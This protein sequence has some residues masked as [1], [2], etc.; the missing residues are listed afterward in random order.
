[1]WL[2]YIAPR[3][4]ESEGYDRGP[5]L[6]GQQIALVKRFPGSN[7]TTIVV[8]NN[9]APVAMSEWIDGVAAVL[10]GWMMGQAGGA[11]IA[12]AVRQG[13][14]FRKTGRDLPVYAL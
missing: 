2:C 13:Q 7:P 12:G 3:P 10:E 6:T 9:G 1:M 5:D 11:A 8:L 4:S 14:P